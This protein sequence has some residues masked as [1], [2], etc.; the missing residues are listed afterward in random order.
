LKEGR[1]PGITQD[2]FEKMCKARNCQPGDVLRLAEKRT[3][4]KRSAR[5]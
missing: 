1:A 3:D 5:K 2:I 4:K